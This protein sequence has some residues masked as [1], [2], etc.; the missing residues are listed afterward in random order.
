MGKYLTTALL[1][2]LS[3]ISSP[4][5]GYALDDELKVGRDIFLQQCA[6]CHGPEGNGDGEITE[7]FKEKPRALSKLSSENGG[8]YPFELVYQTL[9]ATEKVKGHGQ[10]AMPI[11]GYY[12]NV[13]VLDDPN[14]EER[15]AF[16]ALGKM[17][18]VIY[19]I[20]TL[21]EK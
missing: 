8:E 11:W 9:K 16:I 2:T 1:F 20:E 6:G 4:T 12:F 13:E 3:F 10:T 18:S 14:V 5:H 17:L 7:L 19:Y 21:Q 15:E